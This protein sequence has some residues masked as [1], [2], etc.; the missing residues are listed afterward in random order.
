MEERARQVD[1][2]NDGL[3]E[4]GAGQVGLA[5]ADARERRL[6]EVGARQRDEGP[7]ATGHDE[8]REWAAIGNAPAQLAPREPRVEEGAR[9]ERAVRECGVDVARATEP[10]LSE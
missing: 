3:V 7:I 1:V 4:P 2:A 8:C 6:A 10:D 5:E 9:D